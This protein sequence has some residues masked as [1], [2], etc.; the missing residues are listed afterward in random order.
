M[1]FSQQIPTVGKDMEDLRTLEGIVVV[2]V[3][4]VGFMVV[5]VVEEGIT[6][7]VEGKGQEAGVVQ[8]SRS[9]PSV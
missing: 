9:G 4:V 6:V 2:V 5:V 1:V 7:V 3:G 8:A